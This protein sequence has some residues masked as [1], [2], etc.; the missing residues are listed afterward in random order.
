MSYEADVKEILGEIRG[1]MDMCLKNQ[2]R[3]FDRV[4]GLE[5]RLRHLEAHKAYTLGALGVISLLWVIAVE[6]VKGK[7]YAI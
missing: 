6:W 5:E 1:K 3:M 2:E 7:I 4:D